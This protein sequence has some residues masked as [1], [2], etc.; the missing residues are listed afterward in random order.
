MS[1]FEYKNLTPF[2]WFVLE[3][4]P[5]IEADFDALS[6]WQLFCK[7]GNELNKVINSTNT[8]GTQVEDL[9]NYFDNLDVQVEVDNKLN[10][11]AESGELEEIIAQYLNVKG[12]LCF[13]NIEELKNATNLINGSIVKTLGYYNYNDGGGAFYRVRNIINSDNIN[14]M[15]LIGLTNV[16]L[17]GEIVI[18]NNILNVKQ[19][20]AYGNNLN[21]DTNKIQHAVDYSA[22]KKINLYIPNGEYIV[23]YIDFY[24][25]NEIIGENK[26]NTILKSSSNNDKNYIV[27]ITGNGISVKNIK[28]I[29][30]STGDYNENLNKNGII[31]ENNKLNYATKLILKDIEV[32]NCTGSGIYQSKNVNGYLADSLFYN[33]RVLNCERYGCYLKNNSDFI[34]D[35]CY[36]VNNRFDG[37]NIACSSVRVS[38]CKTYLNGVG[39]FN[40]DASTAQIRFHGLVFESS[41]SSLFDNIS[42]ENY[43]HGFIIKSISSNIN[44]NISD[45]NGIIGF[46]NDT[47]LN[48]KEIRKKRSESGPTN[49]YYGYYFLDSQRINAINCNA[50]SFIDINTYGVQMSHLYYFENCVGITLIGSGIVQDTS[51][52]NTNYSFGADD[53][54]I[55]NN[56]I[57]GAFNKFISNQPLF[58][59]SDIVTGASTG[60][61]NINIPIWSQ[62]ICIV[63]LTKANSIYDILMIACSRTNNGITVS[64]VSDQSD[65]TL[66][67]GVNGVTV[68]I[69]SGG[70]YGASIKTI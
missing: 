69:T 32:L 48:N 70:L 1:N 19:F 43:G 5:F 67:P 2:K 30:T 7:L 44:N 52:Y 56:Y 28:I 3:N 57:L 14:D 47:N 25:N 64:K 6:E 51:V 50:T 8:L 17:V 33:I 58:T 65:Y 35:N 11:M 37:L 13:N 62:G 21:N 46:V 10:D 26:I 49:N 23:D 27:S 54:V 22:N 18:N 59:I 12:L 60:S 16:N 29:G 34:I 68:N 53:I 15:D 39:I 41:N 40:G 31:F 63:R 66:T 45:A 4:F 36:F 9:T 38:K 20:G 24:G 61:F 42:Q 55:L